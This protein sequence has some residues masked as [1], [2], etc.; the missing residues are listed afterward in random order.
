[1]HNSL[2]LFKNTLRE[3]RSLTT[4]YD[5]LVSSIA[6]PVNF[7]DILRLQ[8]VYA[9]SAFDKLMHDLIRIGVVSIYAG[10][11]T[12]TPRYKSDA[13]SM[14]THLALINAT[15][16]PKEVL[17]EI[18]V[19]KK[20]KVLSF[21]DPDKI[22]SGLSLIWNEPHKWEK[23]AANMAAPADAVRTRLKL[24]VGRRNSIV[25]ES[26]MDP[27]SQTKTPISRDEAAQ[28]IEFIERCGSSIAVLV[29]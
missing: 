11:R 14:E 29:I 26:D 23:I 16:P 6:A 19:S 28:L 13:I 20:L 27:V 21:Q 25:H 10:T 3:T 18:E 2:I 24:I 7:D 1:M 15:I 12:I 17:F 8:V 5:Y 4:L 9:V 22:A